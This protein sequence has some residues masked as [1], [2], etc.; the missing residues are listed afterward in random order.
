MHS[1]KRIIL[2]GAGVAGQLALHYYGAE[3]VTCFADN[4][5]HGQK[6]YGK[7]VISFDELI[8]IHDQYDVVISANYAVAEVL[9]KQCFDQCIPAIS[10][11][12]IVTWRD[13]ESNPEIRKFQNYHVGR[14]CFLIGNGP[15]L[16]TEDL[17][18]L[19]AGN[20][21][22]FACNR[23]YKIFS[24][25]NWRPDYYFAADAALIQL[26]HKEIAGLDIENKFI[27]NPAQIMYDDSR[28][29]TDVFEHG[30]G[31]VHYFNKIIAY[32]K[33]NGIPF[34]EDPSKAL[35]ITNTVM[36]PMLQ[37]AVYMG[38]SE[39]Y[40]L[41]VDHTFPAMEDINAYNINGTHF[42]AEEPEENK[43][44]VALHGAVDYEIAERLLNID[45]M[46]AEEH[47]RKLGIRVFNATRGGRLEIFK[48]VDFN[49][50]FS[51]H[52]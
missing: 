4:N 6:L 11:G 13:Y 9:K 14:R 34:S 8:I 36:Y 20:E 33:E 27:S 48:R 16:C 52:N 21:I 3:R 35:H 31:V 15:S 23:I 29:I 24:K 19:P 42:Y 32:S 38:F 28:I 46:V 45:Y 41:G 26:Y 40:L 49:T 37:M 47:C 12:E 1:G 7:D 50:L 25:T 30:L 51:E 18:K 17:D 5:K 10:W 39:I 2:F 43:K 44:F 22:S